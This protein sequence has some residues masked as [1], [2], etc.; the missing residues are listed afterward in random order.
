MLRGIMYG[1]DKIPDSWFEKIPGGYYKADPDKKGKP[2]DKDNKLCDKHEKS[3]R[4]RHSNE[5]EER[6]PRREDSYESDPPAR[7]PERSRRHADRSSYDGGDNNDSLDEERERRHARRSTINDADRYGY[8]DGF[9]RRDSTRRSY[10]PIDKPYEPSPRGSQGSFQY[11][12]P[13]SNAARRTSAAA[14]AAGVGTAA[15]MAAQQS[16]RHV[17][18]MPPTITP[19]PSAF[20]AQTPT[21]P[22]Y[23]PYS[24]IYGANATNDRQMFSPP[25]ANSISFVQPTSLNQVAPVGSPPNSHGSPPANAFYGSRRVSDPHNAPY[26]RQQDPY[27]SSRSASFDIA[28]SEPRRARSERRPNRDKERFQGQLLFRP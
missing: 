28:G 4:R 18:S 27:H 20:P 2:N 19:V 22:I 23:V 11:A 5:Y 21:A 3:R 1:A 17:S 9:S 24:D 25:P 14:V 12:D 10:A 7:G 13:H 16:Q 26:D 8:N 6:R 15:T